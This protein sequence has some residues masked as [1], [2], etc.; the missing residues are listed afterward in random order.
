MT[1]I[2]DSFKDLLED[3]LHAMAYLATLMPDGTPQCTPLWFNTDG[4]YILVN[5]A[6]GRIKDR[7]MRARSAVAVVIQDPRDV[8]RYVQ[9]RGQ[10]AEITEEGA[11][12]H[13][14]QLSMKYRQ[15]HW[16]PVDGQTR[17]TY[18]ILPESVSVDD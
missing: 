12:D 1:F 2:P 10:V 14:D 6:K 5:S 16:K 8:M 15:R 3:D 7:N 4:K 11:L 17:V 18:K 9:V 13:I